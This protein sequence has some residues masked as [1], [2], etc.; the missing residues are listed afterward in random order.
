[1]IGGLLRRLRW[2]LSRWSAEDDRVFHDAL[3]SPHHY[4]PFTF[5]Y[6]GY[7]TIRRFADLASARLTSVRRQAGDG[8]WWGSQFCSLAASRG[9]TPAEADPVP[10]V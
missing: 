9:P 1:M 10:Q 3:F 6:P 2:R 5:A 8:P 7:V 4:D